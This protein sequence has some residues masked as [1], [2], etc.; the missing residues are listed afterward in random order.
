[1]VTVS[2][3]V[4]SGAKNGNRILVLKN[5]R[6]QPL[7][8]ATPAGPVSP[9]PSLLIERFDIEP[10][11]WQTH[12]HLNQVVALYLK[13]SRV[14]HKL[15]GGP[16]ADIP[17]GGGEVVICM[18]NHSEALCWKEPASFLCVRISDDA[19]EEAARSMVARNY[20]ELQ[21]ELRSADPRMRSLL[22]A[23]EVERAC[24]YTSGRLFVDSIEAALAALLVSSC[25]RI[26]VKP[27]QNKGGL[28]PQC[29][30]RVLEFMRA[31][32]G[33]QITLVELAKC[34]GLSTSHFSQQFKASMNMSPY[35]YMLALRI[36][37]SKMML[38]NP[39]MSVLDVS[40]AAG[41]ENQQHFATVFRR[42]VGVSPTGYR[43]Q[44]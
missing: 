12:V 42:M 6:I 15:A 24:G 44:P 27:S 8:S 1:M 39:S 26:R 19:L 43:R 20:V 11:D 5:D 36:K 25:S 18:R 34:S 2:T 22:Y 28:S 32:L 33:Q 9:S 21:A 40:L 38:R 16:T 30:R 23:L 4:E 31:N 37:Q 3:P 10:T 14:L 7:I 35:K 17:V 13:P 29:L 41:F